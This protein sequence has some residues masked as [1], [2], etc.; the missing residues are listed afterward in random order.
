MCYSSDLN[1]DVDVSWVPT[2]QALAKA[3]LSLDDIDV[4]EIHEAFAAQVHP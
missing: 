2:Y 3:Q 4:F 1:V